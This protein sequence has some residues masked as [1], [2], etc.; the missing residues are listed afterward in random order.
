MAHMTSTFG[1]HNMCFVKGGFKS[2]Q[3]TEIIALLP[4]I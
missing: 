1:I 3:G 4:A 2:A